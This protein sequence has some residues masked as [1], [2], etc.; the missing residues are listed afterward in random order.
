MA[1]SVDTA[2]V[3]G[4]RDLHFDS[5]DEIVADAERMAD[6]AHAQL[7]NWSLGEICQ[8]LAQSLDSATDDNQVVPSLLFRLIGPFMKK[9]MISQ[10]M[11]PGFRMTSKMQPVFMPKSD[12]STDEGLSALKT[13]VER[14]KLAQLPARSPTFGKLSNAE[15]HQFHCRHAEMHLSF[16]VPTE[17]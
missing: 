1:D 15:W 5:V 12:T 10:T 7:G 16:I 8:H 17:G 3:T 13:A 2:K 11:T 9:R 6:G 4:R 14:F